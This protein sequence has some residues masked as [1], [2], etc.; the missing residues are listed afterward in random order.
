LN[1]NFFAKKHVLNRDAYLNGCVLKR[2]TTVLE[3]LLCIIFDIVKL[4][5]IVTPSKRLVRQIS[6]CW[7]ELDGTRV[8]YC[9]SLQ[10]VSATNFLLLDRARW[11]FIV[12]PSKRLVRQISFCWTELDGTLLSL[13]PS[14]ECEKFPLVGQSSMGLYCHSLHAV[15]A[16]NFLLLDR[17]RWDF[18][19]TPSKRWV[20]KISF[21]WTELDGTLLS[22]PPSG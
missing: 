21:S 20:R 19:V 15:S 14:G 3:L 11:D 12:T 17:A 7:T 4:C 18:I 9:H 8:L 2:E 16:K 1:P 10:A 5:F 6:F 13:P 22:L